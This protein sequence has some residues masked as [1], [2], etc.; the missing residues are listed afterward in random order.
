MGGRARCCRVS[1]PGLWLSQ[2]R[3]FSSCLPNLPQ[4]KLAMF[5][6][7]WRHT[8]VLLDLGRSISDFGFFSSSRA[9]SGGI[10]SFCISLSINFGLLS[11][12]GTGNCVWCVGKAARWMH[13]WQARAAR[14]GCLLDPSLDP[15]AVYWTIIGLARTLSPLPNGGKW[16]AKM[17]R[18][19]PPL[20]CREYDLDSAN[21]TAHHGKLTDPYSVHFWFYVQSR[22]PFLK[23]L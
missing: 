9:I 7:F 1:S 21:E 6:F 18:V 2:P 10:L 3:N 12:D 13:K 19:S 22:V 5:F 11:S 4:K 15:S 16:A 8:L 17:P 20:M 23:G 14:T